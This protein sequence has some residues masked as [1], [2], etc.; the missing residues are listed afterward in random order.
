[1]KTVI[2]N[3]SF[4]LLFSILSFAL[5]CTSY[6]LSDV[7]H[8]YIV[9]IVCGTLLAVS[10]IVNLIF[11]YSR[12]NKYPS[13]SKLLNRFKES[14]KIKQTNFLKLLLIIGYIVLAAHIVLIFLLGFFFTAYAKQ[15]PAYLIITMVTSLMLG[16]ILFY[17]LPLKQP[18]K[19]RYY[20]L[21]ND[22]AKKF[23]SL[24][25]DKHLK[26]IIE[27]NDKLYCTYEDKFTIHFGIDLLPYL[28]KD[29]RQAIYHRELSLYNSSLGKLLLRD[30][31]QVNFFTGFLEFDLIFHFINVLFLSNITSAIKLS[32][33]ELLKL[34][35]EKI[36]LI[37]DEGL[38][39]TERQNYFSAICDMSILSIQKE[40]DYPFNPF[41][42]NENCPLDY[43]EQK[44]KYISNSIKKNHDQII[45]HLKNNPLLL[46]LSD[47]LKCE[48]KIAVRTEYHLIDYDLI[49]Y[50]DILYY[51]SH[52][53]NYELDRKRKHLPIIQYLEKPF[54]IMP[55]LDLSAL[56][57][58][59][60][61]L[62]DIKKAKSYYQESLAI[63][64]NNAFAL[65]HLGE[66]LIK[67]DDIK[68]KELLEKSYQINPNYLE[69]CLKLIDKYQIRNQLFLEKNDS[70]NNSIL[71]IKQ[72]LDNKE[73][74]ELTSN[75]VIKEDDLSDKDYKL[76]TDLAKN[77]SSLSLIKVIK[78]V[79]KDKVKH[80]V[81]LYFDPNGDEID[82]YVC[83]NAFYYLLDNFDLKPEENNFFL[84]TLK[85]NKKKYDVYSSF[86]NSDISKTIYRK[87]ND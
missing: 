39:L 8:N 63:N 49:K 52:K 24:P 7:T 70:D 79:L 14:I 31:R 61:Y 41:M 34:Y 2:K 58:S 17:F 15:Q 38:D 51:Q 85:S 73:K 6:F 43:Y 29:K 4:Q 84:Y 21:S 75:S 81:G 19:P 59:Y 54:S 47:R 55:S 22:D 12:R 77:F 27:N 10:A 45:R 13:S 53:K 1:M 46:K 25:I 20:L 50:F 66:I 78:Q 36:N 9:I 32:F 26:I 56:G 57:F 40:I 23:L 18:L 86:L 82:K 5:M 83:F 11:I 37:K 16:T 74:A 71:K 64:P 72:R 69:S 33:E 80:Y 62:G 3:H 67:E 60:A 28:D 68:G 76:I 48:F 42:R 44:A 87:E 65:F 35:A 30:S